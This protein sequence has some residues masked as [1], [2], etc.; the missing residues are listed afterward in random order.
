MSTA[1]A[2]GSAEKVLREFDKSLSQTVQ[3]VSGRVSGVKLRRFHGFYNILI[4][5]CLCFDGEIKEVRK[6]KIHLL[7]MYFQGLSTAVFRFSRAVLGVPELSFSLL[8]A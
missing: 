6:P 1:V 8:E 7:K 4:I 2:S 5:R 3:F